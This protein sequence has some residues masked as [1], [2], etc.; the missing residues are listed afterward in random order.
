MKRKR[1]RLTGI[2]AIALLLLVGYALA[3]TLRTLPTNYLGFWNQVAQDTPIEVLSLS[4]KIKNATRVKT[5]LELGNPTVDDLS[6][7]YTVF[8]LDG[9]GLT[10]AEKNGT[11]TILAGTSEKMKWTIS[12]SVGDWIETTVSLNHW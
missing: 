10:L 4:H 9:A 8:Y 7:N 1:T 3:I 5:T 12:L 6:V 2:L 11:I